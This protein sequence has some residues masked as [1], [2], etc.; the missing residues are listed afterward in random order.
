MTTENLPS[1]EEKANLFAHP[2][3]FLAT[4]VVLPL[5][6]VAALVYLLWLSM[7][8][9]KA[10]V[11]TEAF[12]CL[13]GVAAI[14]LVSGAYL[15]ICRPRRVSMVLQVVLA[16]VAGVCL[17]LSFGVAGR[18]VAAVDRWMVGAS[19]SF[20]LLC[21]LLPAV[22]AGVVRVA[23]GNW[24]V[25]DKGLN[26]LLSGVFTVLLPAFVYVL[27]QLGSRFHV[28]SFLFSGEFFL[29]VTLLFFI[30]VLRFVHYLFFLALRQR[31]SARYSQWVGCLLFAFALPFG[32]LTLN[33]R[34]PF[35]V[36][37]ANPWAW[38]LTLF[39]G[40]VLLLPV[41]ATRGGL[42]AY[43]LQNVAGSFVL[44]FFFLFLPFLPL[45]IPAIL[46]M[47][48][49]FLILAPLLLFRF[50]AHR[51]S[52]AWGALRARFSRA[53]LVAVALAGLLTLPAFFLLDVECERHDLRVL[54]KWHAQEDFGEPAQPLP[55]SAVRARRIMEHVN[56]DQLGEEIPFLSAWRTIRVYDG[57][58]LADKL[59]NELNQRILGSA[60]ERK[61]SWSPAAD[62]FGF[63]S[64]RRLRG[65][66]GNRTAPDRTTAF[67]ARV[68][69]AGTNALDAVYTVSV[70]AMNPVTANAFSRERELVL[71]LDLPAGAWVEGMRLKMDDGA[72]K[73]AAVRERK[74]AEWV[75]KMITAQRR[76]PSIVT[77]DSPTEG[78][79]KVF[80]VG[81]K[82]REVELRV[83]L[84]DRTSARNVISLAAVP[85][86]A[87]RE[88]R[89][90]GA[91]W[92]TVEV[93]PPPPS[94]DRL[95]WRALANPDFRADRRCVLR[96]AAGAE[97]SVVSSAWM[98]RHLA[99]LKTVRTVRKDLSLASPLAFRAVR[100]L[101]RTE[102]KSLPAKLRAGEPVV[103]VAFS[104]PTNK[105]VKA[106]SATEK[107]T[108][109]RELAGE[110]ALEDA[111]VKG[112]FILP[113]A[114]GG[115]V[116]VPYR[117]GRD[118][119]VFAKVKGAEE[120]GG[121]WAEG[122]KAWA[123]DNEAFLH[124]AID[125]RGD[126]LA[127]AR[128]TGTLTTAAAYIA[129]ET[130]T[131]EKALKLKE[132][133]ALRGNKAFD[134]EEGEATPSSAPGLFSLL[135]GLLLVLL[136]GSGRRFM[137]IRQLK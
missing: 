83:R 111:S 26:I 6:A 47:G 38:G 46:M 129:V 118:A 93:T 75:Y 11:K 40:L 101:L 95:A 4:H 122:A 112:W 106:L 53:A 7:D 66:M 1:S 51:I 70:H 27:F 60:D 131:Q 108:L 133:E 87:R 33:L 16:V 31:L 77:L 44:Y 19:P 21:G 74:A 100:R 82:G 94:R 89:K 109:R 61:S 72:W 124:P 20:A 123:L 79:L 119:L 121:A 86:P 63:N 117:E 68:A 103:Q 49:G 12:V 39:T 102:A 37:F 29:I 69:F 92:Q 28:D 113:A 97:V 116:A 135:V 120:T 90:V 81:E 54:L 23:T 98:E 22:F 62:L 84:P 134:F 110:T 52:S 59:R 76:D 85:P 127:A 88:W 41:R 42:V 104:S 32:G 18:M 48:A 35:P 9:L 10:A 96:T 132:R 57:L 25:R 8:Q 80:P 114:D 126:L 43:Y 15:A 130:S 67:D 105:P 99:E 55:V 14:P 115:D 13:G 5:L 58:C 36:S 24:G 2:F 65:R 64:R 17:F 45:A 71:A 73:T 128:R 137:Q 136:V 30:F 50:W 56:A 125:A 91:K 107:A 3:A 34:V 78:T